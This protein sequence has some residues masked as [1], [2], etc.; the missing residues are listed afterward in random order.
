M[1]IDRLDGNPKQLNMACGR[2]MVLAF[3]W[4]YRFFRYSVAPHG[5]VL[6][7]HNAGLL[8]ELAAERVKE[9]AQQYH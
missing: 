6:S 9:I 5:F 8:L 2:S 1:Y 7:P 4:G 3:V